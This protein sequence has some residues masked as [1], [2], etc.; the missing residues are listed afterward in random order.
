MVVLGLV[1]GEPEI[2]LEGVGPEGV[3][4][5]AE[6]GQALHIPVV[7]E[8]VHDRPQ[9][10]IGGLSPVPAHL[11]GVEA[12][13]GQIPLPPGVGP[14]Q[15]GYLPLGQVLGGWWAMSGMGRSSRR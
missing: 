3:L 14:I 6:D 9:Y 8:E 7:I 1:G 11:G 2:P 12:G 5:G 4:P 10:G 15:L 13:D